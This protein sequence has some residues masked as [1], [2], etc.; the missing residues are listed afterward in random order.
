MSKPSTFMDGTMKYLILIA[1]A[2]SFLIGTN[3]IQA[4]TQ[5]SPMRSESKTTTAQAAKKNSPWKLSSRI[6]L[7][8]GTN[9]GYLVV[10][11]DLAEGYHVYSVNPKGSPSPTKFEVPQTNDLRL[12]S[13]FSSEKPPK[14]I[15]R[16]PVFNRRMEKHTGKVQF[17]AN[18]EVRPGIDLKKLTQEVLLSGQVC[19]DQGCQLIRKHKSNAG[20]AGYFELPPASRKAA[21]EK[22]LK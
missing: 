6:H 2:S 18:I 21:S 4:Q 12:L 5:N 13:K 17:F 22:T 8:K 10:Q 1:I 3:L 20:F 15:E 9:K 11:L 7:E 19:S 14:V 16:D